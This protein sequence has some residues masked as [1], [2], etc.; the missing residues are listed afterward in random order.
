M[1]KRFFINLVVLM[2]GFSLSAQTHVSVPLDNPIYYLLDQ[3]QLRGLCAPLPAVKPYSQAVI[4]A[5]IN[6]ILSSSAKP[7]RLSDTER[8][9]LED[10]KKGFTKA[11]AGL[12]WQRGAYHFETQAKKSGFRFSGDAGVSLE[13]VFSGS[14]YSGNGAWGTDSWLTGYANGDIGEHFSFGFNVAGGFIRAPHDEL[15]TYHTYYRGFIDN[16]NYIDQQITTY[17]QPKAF[18]PYT[19]QKHWDGVMFG[20]GEISAGSIKNWPD[21][22][23]M[24]VN[25]ISELGGEFFGQALTY[26]F[27]RIKREW[28]GMSEGSSLI[29]NTAARPFVAFEATFNPVYWFSFSALTGGLEYYNEKGIKDSSWTSQNAFS[30]EQ[31]EFNYKNYVHFDVGSTAIW[32]KRFE[33]GYIFPINNNFL[34]QYNI[35]DFDNMGLFFDIKAQYPGIAQVW[36]SF[37]A[38]EIEVSSAS[39]MFELDRHMFALQGGAKVAIPWLPFA[40]ATL[41]Y[42]KIEP[43]CYTHTRIF[44]PWN[45]DADN[46]MPMETSYT[47][48]GESIGYYLPPNSDELLLRFETMPLPR[49]RAHFQYQMIRH[50][51]DFGSSAV[52]GSSFLSELDP[53]GRSEKKELRKYFLHDGAYQWTHIIK[54]GASHTFAKIPLQVFGEAGVVFSAFTN[55]EDPA[56]SGSPS[57][58]SFIDTAE[59]PKST[60]II[61]TI[62]LRLFPDW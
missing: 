52:D 28:A 43:Y 10:A 30:I 14:L 25:L 18:F 13:S 51:A 39:K 42:T 58:Y 54:A 9:I 40:S 22:M 35:G 49:I 36:F 34:Y 48:N 27:G 61:I 12:D 45:N 26:R 44:V 15:G 50:G 4:V 8:R 17:S 55:I 3:A 60:G 29:F 24:S 56:N 59:Y 1:V 21:N 46:K 41:S 32:P 57:S 23:A 11:P 2:A 6:E 7:G 62:G 33:L 53:D 38:D 16:E 19:Y 37:F 5:A 20:F 47:N 31:L